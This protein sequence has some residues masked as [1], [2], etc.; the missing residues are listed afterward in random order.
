MDDLIFSAL[1]N[2]L[3]MRTNACISYVSWET[4]GEPTMVN[5]LKKGLFDVVKARQNGEI[6]TVQDYRDFLKIHFPLRFAKL[7]DADEERYETIM[8][9]R[10][11]DF[12]RT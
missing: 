2:E 8:V 5:D 6:H 3:K 1:I 7:P 10:N 12:Q 9:E 4:T 11:P